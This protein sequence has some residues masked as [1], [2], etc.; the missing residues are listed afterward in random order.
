MSFAQL[1]RRESLRD[2][3]L[4]LRGMGRK[5]YQMGFRGKVSR[6]TLADA[7]EARSSEIYA[8]FCKVLIRQARKLY[9]HES[10]SDS[11]DEIVYVLDSTYVGLC[12]SMY[13]WAEAGNHN[14]AIVKL[15][16]VLDLKGSIP[17]FI[18]IS[19]YKTPDNKLLDKLI[20]EPGAFYVMDK[21]YLDFA[22]LYKLHNAKGYFVSRLKTLVK[23]RR[24]HSL[25]IDRSTG[26]RA[27]QVIKLSGKRS[28]ANF[29][30]LLR[31]VSFYCSQTSNRLVFVSNNFHL[32]AAD[33]AQLYKERWKIEIFFK[34]IKQNLRIQKFYGSSKN[35]VET[36]IWIAIANYL[37]IAIAKKKL[38]LDIP[39]QR[40]LQLVSI[41][42]FEK[43]PI[44]A[45][46]Q[47]EP[48]Q[49]YAHDLHKQ[50]KIFHS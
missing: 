50:L 24:Q 6:S 34:W 1:T 29:P 30:D 45:M 8:D 10:F 33:I 49:E 25:P 27:D 3:E 44:K 48:E 12:L 4:C 41:T 40:L 31:R 19:S 13:P 22:R 37:I 15:N 36:Q 7:N 20:V 23:Y 2:I 16:T 26:V 5:L 38:R 9:A 46:S 39:L 14:K 42:L 18:D 47:L 21:G 11:L 43:I 35:A 17:S 28:S 32:P